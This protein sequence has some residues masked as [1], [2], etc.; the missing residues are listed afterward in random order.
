MNEFIARYSDRIQGVLSG[1]DR[2]VFRGTLRRIAYPFGMNG[3][4]WANQVLL[5][6][7]G[8]HGNKVSEQVK[9]AALR[10]V[11]E[12][13]RTVEYLQ[14]CKTD[15][16]KLARALA[17]EQKITDGPV[18]AITCVEPC[19]GFD[20]HR[21]RETRQLDLVQ[22]S[23][24]CLYVYQYWQHPVLG[25]LNARIETWFPFSIQICM[26]GREWL[27]RQM[28]LASMEY[29]QQDNCFPWVADWEQA[30]RLM[31]G[32]MKA[33]WPGLLNH[34]AGGL[35]PLHEE[36]FRRFPLQYYW[37][38]YQSEWATDV[39][40]GKADDLRRLYP[41]WVH[42]AVTTFRSPDVLRFLG[43]NAT[44][45]GNVNGK[46]TG[47]VT[48]DM[49]RRQE[50]VRIKH[51]YNDNS[52]KLYD[53]AYTPQGSVLRAELTMENPEDFKV[54]RRREGDPDGPM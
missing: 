5:K 13:G 17:K 30:Q 36:I 43:K 15:K 51:R 33:D 49:K 52:V 9:E 16:E 8:A 28:D 23:R 12:A 4:L 27:A 10:C 35:N 11:R 54:Y 29:V 48:S 50:G 19:W 39:V 22:R 21:N 6:D 3:Y 34:I 7:F 44:A 18:C 53:K 26:N 32:Q 46:V 47:E 41:L 24:K 2:L 45:S 37:S 38:T 14:S 42:H 25:W 20:I 1:F 40:F 31:D